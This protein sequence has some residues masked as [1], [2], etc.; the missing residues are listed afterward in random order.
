[1]CTP[2]TGQSQN[3][4]GYLAWMLQIHA[5]RMDTVSHYFYIPPAADKA[6]RS[7]DSITQASFGSPS[8]A[9]PTMKNVSLSY[10]FFDYCRLYGMCGM[11]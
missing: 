9:F 8:L 11:G 2:L 3:R 5:E 6:T 10:P 7:N 1:M 4:L